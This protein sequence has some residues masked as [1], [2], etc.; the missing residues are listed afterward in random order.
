MSGAQFKYIENKIKQAAENF[1]PAYHEPAWDRM[2]VL[3]EE[4]KRKKRPVYWWWV[5]PVSLLISVVVLYQITPHPSIKMEIV[6]KLTP[7]KPATET[8][9]T[10]NN[11]IIQ[12]QK[13]ISSSVNL[14]I[15]EAAKKK[16]L[17][18]LP[19]RDEE[20]KPAPALFNIQS[21]AEGELK[22]SSTPIKTNAN[23]VN[24]PSLP[25]VNVAH[26][27]D[28]KI[29][30]P[31]ETEHL[32][33]ENKKNDSLPENKETTL[34]KRSI[35]GN[36][37]SFLSK[38][39][40]TATGGAEAPGFKTF[41]NSG[42]KISTKS[43]LGLGY[44]INNQFSLE[45]GFYLGSKKYISGPENYNY[46]DDSYWNTVELTQVNANCFVYEIPLLIRYNFFQKKS[47]LL[48][49][50][51]GVESFIMQREDYVY[52]YL[53]NGTQH[54]SSRSY[55]GNSHFL[56]SIQFSIGLEKKLSQKF[57]LLFTP[58]ISIPISGVGNGKVKLHSTSLQAGIKYFPFQK[59]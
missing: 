8:M 54:T 48:N 5:I 29:N 14:N 31:K 41:S 45:T 17:S 40:I 33:T 12:K 21:L 57:S 39:Y 51:G 49:V 6:K 7:I 30:Q 1:Q 47:L 44:Q 46:P 15:E 42:S 35:A 32:I 13:I 27:G 38:L 23:E 56:S 4:E 24:E 36:K 37:N 34:P 11:S 26:I 52:D 19:I 28:N 43:G 22:K 9:V 18:I 2:E 50:S 58:F 16:G 55:E 3:L 59:K 10:A 20:N 25:E 53:K